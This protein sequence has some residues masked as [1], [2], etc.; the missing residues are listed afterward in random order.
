VADR[1]ASRLLRGQALVEAW[2]W[3][4]SQRNMPSQNIEFLQESTRTETRKAFDELQVLAQGLET[5]VRERTA[6]ISKNLEELRQIN[7][8]LRQ[9]NEEKDS[10]IDDLSESMKD[11]VSIVKTLR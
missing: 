7:E 4:I 2:D 8:K 6:S 9:T 10:L 5:Q 11:I 1:D 3:D